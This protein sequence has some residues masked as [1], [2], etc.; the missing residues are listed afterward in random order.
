ME[1]EHKRIGE[2]ECPRIPEQ[3]FGYADSG[4]GRN[5]FGFASQQGQSDEPPSGKDQVD[6]DEQANHPKGRGRPVG[7]DQNA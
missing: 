3:L 1:P 7:P 5:G 4:C 6:A 2:R